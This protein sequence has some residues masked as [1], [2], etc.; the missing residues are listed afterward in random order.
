MGADDDVE[1]DWDIGREVA[2]NTALRFDTAILFVT[3]GL[4]FALIRPVC[5]HSEVADTGHLYQRAPQ[6]PIAR[7]DSVGG[8]QAFLP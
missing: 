3:V 4:C 6:Q 1:G 5:T 7:V 8:L 2:L